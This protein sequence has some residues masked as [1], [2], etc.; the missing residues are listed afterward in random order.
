MINEIHYNE[1]DPTVHSEF[2]ELH[3]P[4]DLPVDASGWYFDDGV[5]F[6]FPSGTV[7]AAGGYLVIAE[8]PATIQT[9]FGLSAASVLNWNTGVVP[10]VYNRLQNGGEI[11]VLRTPS[12]ERVDE[13]EYKL[14]FPWPT[15]GDPPDYSIN[16]SIPDSTTTWVAIGAGRMDKG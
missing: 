7:V 4:G 9:K 3:N 13:V 1:D 8:D 11:I 14:G 15:V 16:W 12:G 6:V 5:P 10:P 2:I